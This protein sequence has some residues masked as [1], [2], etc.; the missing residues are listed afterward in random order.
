MEIF[1]TQALLSSGD[2]S[3][4]AD[5]LKELL[6]CKNAHKSDLDTSFSAQASLQ[7][8]ILQLLISLKQ[9]HIIPL[10]KNTAEIPGAPGTRPKKV[11]MVV[12]E[13]E[14]LLQ[15]CDGT[16]PVFSTSPWAI[17]K[18]T[19]ALLSAT[20]LRY[21]GKSDLVIEY[22][23]SGLTTTSDE[24]KKYG[25]EQDDKGCWGKGCSA[26]WRVGPFLLFRYL[27]L[28]ILVQTKLLK[29]EFMDAQ[30][31]LVDILQFLD[32]CPSMGASVR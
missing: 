31:A 9:G 24:L 13:M 10:V 30:A 22:V 28:E 11:P 20:I 16:K 32:A 12:K 29:C 18:I 3:A 21:Q 4:A 27:L 2:S 5:N 25:M 15:K 1:H 19:A 23:K 14:D 26:Q 8:L 7:A 6:R 17:L